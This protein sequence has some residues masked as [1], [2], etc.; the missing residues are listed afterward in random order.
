[1]HEGQETDEPLTSR[2]SSAPA[3]CVGESLV[4]L[5]CERPVASFAEADSF[6]PHLGGAP[7]N[8]AVT[9]AREGAEVALAGG[10]GDDAWGRWLEAHL[11]AAHVDLRF[12]RL[13]PGEETAVAF[14]V[15]D[16]DA[17]PEFLIYGDGIRAA[18]VALEPQ[19]ED[20]VT[21]SSTVVIGSNTMVGEAERRV[22][23]RAREL[24]L[25]GGAHVLFDLNLRLQRWRDRDEAVATARMACHGALLVKV[26]A[27]EA[28][29]LTGESE[30]V[31]AADAMTRFGCRLA[32]VT[33]GPDGAVL[34]GEAEASAAGVAASVVDPTGAGDT[35]M[36][37]VVAALVSSGYDPAAA[38]AALPRAVERAAR[39]TEHFGAIV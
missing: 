6:V 3:L 9:A 34:G 31:R 26:N 28:V 24:A 27:D 35:L 12:W 4:D 16:R 7:T 18:M 20:A 14:A 13:L 10:V 22:T 38:A 1:L 21:S 36:G 2:G 33:L 30:P 29:L 8:V 32:L 23:L 17:V 15:L 5:I 39:T 37:V 25:A 11:R 19:L